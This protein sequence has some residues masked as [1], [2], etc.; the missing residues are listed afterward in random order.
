MLGLG[1]LVRT[2]AS[3]TLNPYAEDLDLVDVGVE[4]ALSEGQRMAAVGL[5]RLMRTLTLTPL[6]NPFAEDLDLVDLGG[7]EALS[8][9]QRA[10]VL[11][12]SCLL[13]FLES[14]LSRASFAYMCSRCG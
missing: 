2:L 5:L 1:V 10:A 6:E 3:T 13:P 14:E 9:G 4:E 7:E 8:E 11:E 12:A